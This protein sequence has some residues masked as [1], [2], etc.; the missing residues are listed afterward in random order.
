[1]DDQQEEM[2]IADGQKYKGVNV[3]WKSGKSVVT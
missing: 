1:M 2:P 3:Q